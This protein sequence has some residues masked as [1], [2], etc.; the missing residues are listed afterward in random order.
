MAAARRDFDAF[1]NIC[2]HLLVIDHSAPR[3]ES[4]GI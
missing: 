1:D 3:G 2:D 4:V